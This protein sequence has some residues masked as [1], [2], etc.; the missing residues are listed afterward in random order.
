MG[1]KVSALE[2]L[3]ALDLRE[4]SSPVSTSRFSKTKWMPSSPAIADRAPLIGEETIS[5]AGKERIRMPPVG[6]RLSV[7][8]RTAWRRSAGEEWF[9]ADERSGDRRGGSDEGIHFDFEKREV[10][11]GR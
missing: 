4:K 1:E 2:Y 6:L 9:F 7:R 3:R 11:T 10:E 8:Q 5:I